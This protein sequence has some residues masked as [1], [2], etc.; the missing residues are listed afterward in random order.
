MSISKLISKYQ[1][2]IPVGVRN[3]VNIKKIKLFDL[4]YYE[5]L[6]LT[7]SEWGSEEDNEAYVAL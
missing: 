4:A 3:K 7:L 5:A 2:T 1:A 6:E